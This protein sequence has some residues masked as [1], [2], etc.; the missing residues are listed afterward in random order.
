MA[1][2]DELTP[3]QRASLT[4]QARIRRH[5]KGVFL[6]HEGDAAGD[7]LIIEQ[8]SVKVFVTASNGREVV[9]DVAEDGALLGELSALDGGDRSASAVTL[10]ETR[11]ITLRHDAFH[12]WIAEHPAVSL[13]LLRVLTSRIRGA[14][15]RQLEFG[16]SD[17]IGRL[18]QRLVDLAARQQADLAGGPVRLTLPF[19]QT[20][21]AGWA[22][23]SR[24]AIVKALQALR[25][26][27]WV[28]VDGRTIELL[29]PAAVARRAEP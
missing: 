12:A 26:L 11:L 8:G 3:A 15:R 9:V 29:Q 13:T 5:P 22:G 16:S 18:C 27:G 6:F 1:F 21:L 25:Q 19:S 23:L 4:G 28:T 10:G 17:A 20:D 14:T 7:V 2:L 24:E